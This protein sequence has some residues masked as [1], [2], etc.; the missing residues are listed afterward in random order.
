MTSPDLSSPFSR[1]RMELRKSSCESRTSSYSRSEDG[2]SSTPKFVNKKS[3]SFNDIEE[4]TPSTNMQNTRSIT[5][6]EVAKINNY[7]YNYIGQET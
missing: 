6:Q 2:K 3:F 7:N 4:P 5:K 1:F